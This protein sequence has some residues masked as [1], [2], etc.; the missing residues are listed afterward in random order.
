MTRGWL[1]ALL[2]AA[3]CW[4]LPVAGPVA[5]QG[6]SVPPDRRAA[7]FQAIDDACPDCRRTGFVACGGPAIG[8]GRAFAA[9]ALQGTPRRGYLVGF[10]MTGD[11]FR[12][13][14][15]GTPITPLVAGLERRFAR[16]RLIV[17]EDGF[18]RARVLDQTP[19]V[20]VTMPVE[21]HSCV[22]DTK[23]AWGCCTGAGC[24]GSGECC[25]K[26]LGS[27][28]VSL[29]WF[30]SMVGEEVQFSFRH[31][32]GEARLERQAGQRSTTYFCATDRRYGLD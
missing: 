29:T 20:A 26:S 6:L 19:R 8:P 3:F 7:L 1:P 5:G 25:E 31:G 10:V 21:L 18:A 12:N 22:A 13:V 2:L 15:R 28:S 9:S 11:D 23:K 4:A 16:A 30:N 17:L 27:P 14:V 32:V 24:R